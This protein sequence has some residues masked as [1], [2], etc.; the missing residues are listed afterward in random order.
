ML[1][2]AIPSYQRRAH[3]DRLLDSIEA[4]LAE[5]PGPEE[6]EGEPLDAS[7][8]EV[9][10]VLDGSDDGS[11]ELVDARSAGF[12]VRLRGVWQE[13][14]GPAGARNRCAA[15]ATHDLLWYLD[16]DLVVNRRALVAHLRWDRDEAPMVMG[17]CLIRSDTAQS[18]A[19]K[20]WY[21]ARW[22][23]LASQRLL[24]DPLVITFANASLPKALI[25]E[26]PF[27]ERFRGYG[28]EDVDLAIRLVAA[29]VRVGYDADAGVDHDFTP[30]SPERLR[31]L[32]E[33][34]RNRMLLLELHPA[35][36][37]I[38]FPGE[39]GR[40]ERI[41][42]RAAGLPVVWRALWPTAVALGWVG[43]RLSKDRAVQLQNLA[44]TAALNAGIADAERDPRPAV[45]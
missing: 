6:A 3:V 13:N 5:A 24:T 42:R 34:G 30:S 2:I 38:I 18:A 33:E 43:H 25:E 14:T 21:D 4:A 8:I 37:D 35:H 31:K 1:T 28:G 29:G 12:P 36:H 39:P 17:P 11:K 20:E 7:R 45:T 27:V 32:R 40:F 41:T 22:A 23:A 19:A 10:V 26:H 15:E 16:D 44:E 9:L